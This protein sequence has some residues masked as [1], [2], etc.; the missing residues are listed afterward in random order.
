M[1][2]LWL[3]HKVHKKT[4]RCNNDRFFMRGLAGFL[5]LGVTGCFRRALGAAMLAFGRARL[6]GT[7]I[8]CA[9]AIR[10]MVAAGLI[11]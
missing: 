9:R 7:T 8:R 5:S 4:G 6:I 10:A 3:G 2:G 11:S 1:P